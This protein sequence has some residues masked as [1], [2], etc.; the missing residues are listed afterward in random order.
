MNITHII[1][2]AASG[3]IAASLIATVAACSPDTS[4]SGTQSA[5]QS[6][7]SSAAD[8]IPDIDRSGEGNFP[9]VT[10][11]FGEEPEIKAGVGDPMTQV[12]VK[13]L[14]QG[15]GPEITP[16]DSVVVNYKLAL[17][18]GTVIES[19]FA[20]GKPTSFSLDK[21]IP[22]WKYGLASQR[23]GDRVEL[24]VPAQ[25][26]YGDTDKGSIPAGSTLVFVVDILNSSSNVVIN[27]EDSK[28]ATATGEALQE[29]VT[30]TGKAGEEP[31][32]SFAEG[33]ALPQEGA[34]VTV[35]RGAGAEIKA[36]DSVAYKA[37]L[38]QFGKNDAVRSSWNDAPMVLDSTQ[39][40]F[41]G[42]TVG[43]RV[44]ITQVQAASASAPAA[45]VV[46][47]LDIVGLQGPNAS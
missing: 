14:R 45:A 46:W 38:A 15:T 5:A 25:W 32:V 28:N 8:S 11:N 16:D 4:Q 27:E 17:W 7:A 44:V 36:G 24:V 30:V 6:G 23:V 33:A 37:V 19:S 29:G 21:V 47:V 20:S 2:R 1:R 39:G 10:G 12:S 13:T 9:E 40:R 34:T 41:V 31:Q 42:M 18:N 26:G 43:S 22:G 3:I 35:Y